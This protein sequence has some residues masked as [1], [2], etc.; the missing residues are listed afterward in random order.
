MAA[1]ATTPPAGGG[2]IDPTIL[3]LHAKVCRTMAHPIR[4]ALMNALRDGERSVGDLAEAVDVR[5]PLVS[6]HLA[7][8]RN[9]G[10]LRY[11]RSGNEVFY[12]IAYP[13][14]I[15]ACDLLRE[16]L[17]EHLR[18]QEE[19]LAANQRTRGSD[20]WQRCSAFSGKDFELPED[21]LY[22]GARQYWVKSEGGLA[23]VGVSEPGVALTVALID[24]EVFPEAGEELVVDQEIAFATT[25][26]N[27]KYFLSPLAGRVV[28]ANPAATAESVNAQP[29]ETWLVKIQPAAGWER[30][31]ARRRGL[32]DEAPGQASTP[33]PR[34]PRRPRPARARPPASRSTAASR[35]REVAVK[36]SIKFHPLLFQAS[37]AAGGV[38][39]MPFNYLQ[40]GI[41]HGKGLI[42]WANIPWSTMTGAQ[43]ALYL[44]LVALMLAFTVLHFGLTGYFLW[45]LAKWLGQPERSAPSWTSPR[46]TRTRASSPSSLL[47]P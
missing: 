31:S 41:D 32:R 37:L 18:S 30:P 22:D 26:K 39:L 44:P 38:A 9:Q 24:L 17:F 28:E 29:Y 8:L 43:Y 13:K 23:V 2:R 11:R 20:P 7:A 6:Q 33:P 34:R 35:R 16:V 19:L 10:L 25:K 12:R 42:T 47:S 1:G 36:L 46:R 14:M 45:R 4:L 3:E 27:M 5:Q 15:Q 40:Y 21:R